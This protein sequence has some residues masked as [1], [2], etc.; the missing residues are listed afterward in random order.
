M[1]KVTTEIERFA[2]KHE[3]RLLRHDN[4]EVIQLLNNSVT[5]KAEENKTL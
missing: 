4:V 1:E 3:D 5:T 2:R